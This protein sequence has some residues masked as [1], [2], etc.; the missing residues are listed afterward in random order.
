MF[1]YRRNHS[2]SQLSPRSSQLLL[3]RSR[4]QLLNHNHNRSQLLRRNQLLRRSQLLL[5]R[6]RSQ[7][8]HRNRSQLLNH[9]Q[10]LFRRPPST[11]LLTCRS[12]WW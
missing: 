10:R 7:L 9:S 12:R 1:R 8:L 5:R 11:R 2:H 3:R 6:N 4:N